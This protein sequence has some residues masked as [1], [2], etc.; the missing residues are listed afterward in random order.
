MRTVG[1]PVDAEA[2]TAAKYRVQDTSVAIRL[3]MVLASMHDPSRRTGW[4]LYDAL[5]LR[6]HQYE[7]KPIDE[8]ERTIRPWGGTYE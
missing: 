7:S 2:A 3:S 4:V 5:G 8:L 1:G 6:S